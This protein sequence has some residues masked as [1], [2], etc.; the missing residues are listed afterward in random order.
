MWS[1]GQF[2]T[3]P[4]PPAAWARTDPAATL[5]TAPIPEAAWAIQAVGATVD[6]SCC[7]CCHSCVPENHPSTDMR[8]R[9]VDLAKTRASSFRGGFVHRDA[10]ADSG[11]P[12]RW[13]TSCQRTDPKQR[14]SYRQRLKPISQ[15][16][17]QP[18]RLLHSGIGKAVCG[19]S[20][21]TRQGSSGRR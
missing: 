9:C 10:H 4:T 6:G 7:Q 16:P 19:Q 17:P 15:I 8:R 1:G 12:R 14:P 21:G 3:T 11:K 20:L 5:T 2:A 13:R 18:H